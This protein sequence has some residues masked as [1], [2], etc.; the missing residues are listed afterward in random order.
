M[1]LR[2]FDIVRGAVHF[3]VFL[4]FWLCLIA[5]IDLLF[6]RLTREGALE[7]LAVLWPMFLSAVVVDVIFWEYYRIYA[8]ISCYAVELK[9]E[10]ELFG[11]ERDSRIGNKLIRIIDK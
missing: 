7:S 3:Y 8:G 11:N 2:R 10:C 1:K 6:H 9:S 5:I 4:L